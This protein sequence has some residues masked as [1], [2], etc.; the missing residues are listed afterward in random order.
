MY[1]SRVQFIIDKPNFSVIHNKQECLIIS[2]FEYCVSSSLK[3]LNC[4]HDLHLKMNQKF[5]YFSSPQILHSEN[6]KELC[7]STIESSK[8]IFPGLYIA[9]GKPRICI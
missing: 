6:D 2:S 4:I 9:R 7:N 1:T 5:N 8:E 3:L